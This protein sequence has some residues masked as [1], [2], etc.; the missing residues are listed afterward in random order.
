MGTYSLLRSF[1]G[2]C[3]VLTVFLTGC[4]LARVPL[5]CPSGQTGDGIGHCIPV[6]AMI[7]AD[8]GP[9]DARVDG[10]RDAGPTDAGDAALD[11]W[12]EPD[13][14]VMM[15]DAGDM[16]DT[17]SD[18]GPPPVDAGTDS[19]PPSVDAGMDAGPLPVDAGTD[20]GP[21]PVDAGSDA[22]PPDAG[23]PDAGPP[24]PLHIIYTG[25]G[26]TTGIAFRVVWIEPPPIGR[27]ETRWYYA[28]C[29]LMGTECYASVPELAPTR[30]IQFFPFDA[31]GGTA[32]CTFASCPTL[33]AGTTCPGFPGSY[34]VEYLEMPVSPL[35][36]QTTALDTN[37]D[38]F[39]DRAYIEGRLP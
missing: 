10:G 33:C 30:M 29:D 26:P 21:P 5:G 27:Q 2:A 25:A 7:M 34:T 4:S 35:T 38:G 15:D 37:G 22:G 6:D 39:G 1:M 28:E 36:L 17:G 11:A 12:M 24:P 18:S 32:S 20:A 13:A 8:A 9:I 16:P 14:L 31:S 19:G 3:L 23:P